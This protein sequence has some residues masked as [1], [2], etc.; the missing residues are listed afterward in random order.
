MSTFNIAKVVEN[1]P[2]PGLDFGY[3]AVTRSEVKTFVI[4]NPTQSVV[5]FDI[6]SAEAEETSFEIQPLTG[7]LLNLN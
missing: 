1:I 2:Q 4:S 3:C 5:S 7:K 6:K